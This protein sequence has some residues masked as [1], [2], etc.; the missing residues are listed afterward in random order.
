MK[1]QPEQNALRPIHAFTTLRRRQGGFSLV[2]IMVALTLSLILLAGVLAVMYS[3][4]VTYAENERVGRLQE[5]GRAALELILRDLRGAGFPGCA[6]PIN[7]LFDIT[8]TLANPTAVAWNL[9]Q[10]VFGFEG[11]GGVWAPALDAVLIPGATI[12]NDIVVVRTIPTGSP[13]MRV[14]AVVNPTG[15]ILVDK[16]VSELLTVGAPA[17]ISDC[18]NASIFVVNQFNP[19]GGNISAT[20]VRNIGGGPPGN[21]TDDLGATFAPGARVSPILSIA[22]YVAPNAAGTGPALWRVMSNGAPQ[23]II[24]GVEAMQIRYGVDTDGNMTIND[25]VNANLVADWSQVISVSLA[26][27]VRSGEATSP[28]VDSRV[29]TL[30]DTALLPFND[31]FQR[32]LFTTTVTLRNRTN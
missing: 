32:A 14:S 7:G 30:L 16:E 2:E 27:L 13:S 19:G 28:T 9:A 12:N 1:Q 15:P 11:A 22:Y 3:S 10:P 4:K 8:N 29:Y 5:N 21:A 20:I 6:Q 23:E 31:R 17:I 24:P 25:Y 26:M 18:G